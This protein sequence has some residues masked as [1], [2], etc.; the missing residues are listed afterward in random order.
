M[1][2]R[3]LD[4]I[5]PE[6][7]TDDVRS[8]LEDLTVVSTWTDTIG[9][10]TAIV[11]VLLDSEHTETVFDRLETRFGGAEGF[12]LILLPVE[13]TLPRVEA[14]PPPTPDQPEEAAPPTKPAPARISREELYDDI[15]GS[16]KLNRVYVTTVVLSAVVAAVGLLRDNSTIIIG[17]MVIAPL[18]GP[19]IALALATTLGDTVLAKRAI[20]VNL[21]GV[22]VAFVFS[23][24][25]GLFLAVDP[26]VP[27]VAARTHV[28][29][30]DIV[31]ALAS[32][33]AG[34]LAFTTGAP[35]ALVGVM[36]AVALLPPLATVGLLISSGYWSEA[37]GALT[38]LAT[39][40]VCVNLAAVVTFLLQGVRPKT[41][42][43]A[44]RAR[45]ATYRAVIAWTILLALLVLLIVIGF[46]G[47]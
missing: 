4:I 37:F 16:L 26:T 14:P 9:D 47:H 36:V 39:N 44:A 38:L 40:V 15:A 13:A 30:G 21:V 23:I 5:I 2:L 42:W 22:G 1:A 24:V 43:E 7:R 25:V 11:R 20:V 8:T 46:G 41:W 34:A 17:A 33:A 31:L 29:L 35:A 6:D 18:L 27:E 32:G 19:N 3:L 28:A 12:R 45:K 10:S